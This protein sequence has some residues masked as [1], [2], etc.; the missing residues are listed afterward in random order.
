MEIGFVN[1][2]PNSNARKV[3]E[4]MRGSFVLP[5]LDLDVELKLPSWDELSEKSLSSFKISKAERDFLSQLGDGNASEGLRCA[6]REAGFEGYA[7]TLKTNKVA[8]RKFQ[9]TL[10]LIASQIKEYS[11]K[12]VESRC[13]HCGG[14][15]PTTLDNV[16]HKL[17]SSMIAI[18]N[19]LSE[20]Y[21]FFQYKFYGISRSLAG[22]LEDFYKR[23][24][25][26]KDFD[27]KLSRVLDHYG[28]PCKNK[29]HLNL[30][31]SFNQYF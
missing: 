6:L 14:E 27:Y 7:N 13:A 8:E 21:P 31:I 17:S 29:D 10:N 30:E 18:N 19:G 11:E 2:D 3:V 15:M 26:G 24:F 22:K 28:S 20:N 5:Q 1:A 12:Y 25:A 4:K 23:A 9:E 16:R